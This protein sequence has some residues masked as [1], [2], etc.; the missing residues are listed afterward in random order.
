MMAANARGGA[1]S[2]QEFDAWLS[3]QELSGVVTAQEAQQWRREA[4]E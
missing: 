1:I 2:A 4:A 3:D